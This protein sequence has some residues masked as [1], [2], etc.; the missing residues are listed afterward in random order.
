M[1]IKTAA[2]KRFDICSDPDVLILISGVWSAAVQSDIWRLLPHHTYRSDYISVIKASLKYPTQASFPHIYDLFWSHLLFTANICNNHPLFCPL[3]GP[4]DK[5]FISG[6]FGS[7]I[8]K[9][10]GT[11]EGGFWS[12]RSVEIFNQLFPCTLSTLLCFLVLYLRSGIS[13]NYGY[14]LSFGGIEPNEYGVLYL[15]YSL[16]SRYTRNFW[17]YPTFR[18]TWYPIIFKTETGQVGFTKRCQVEDRY[19]DSGGS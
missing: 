1:L 16:R 2:V 19:Q 14:Y 4:T 11:V 5:F 18:V 9:K 7:G 15:K 17:V 6:G 13:G 3:K 8:K 12:G 10:S